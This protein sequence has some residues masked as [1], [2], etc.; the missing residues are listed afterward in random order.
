MTG[1]S[2]F[3]HIK[4]DKVKRIGTGIAFILYPIF[5]GIAFIVHPNLL[6]LQIGGP[7]EE[8]IAEFHGNE[9]LHFGHFLML[10]G[11][12]L[13]IA[14]AVHFMNTLKGRGAWLGFI[15]GILAVFGAVVL[16]ADKSALCLVPSAFDSLP[17]AYFEQLTPAIE[18]MFS[19]KGY[20][21]F[22]WL[23]ALLP[24]GF[25]IQSLGLVLSGI[26]PRRQSVPMLAGSILLAN[27]DIDIIGL[28]ATIF[29]AIGFFPYGLQL[30]MAKTAAAQEPVSPVPEAMQ[31]SN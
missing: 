17:E 18:A 11:V 26:I 9:L 7:I 2:D 27:P 30:I 3:Q 16:A 23:L 25:A 14:I 10:L 15:G 6:N 29:L 8:R 24:I 21:A 28:T 13:L 12:P 31:S 19:Y 20:L 5:S 22:L 1:N 4:L